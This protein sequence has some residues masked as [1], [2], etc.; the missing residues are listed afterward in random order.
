VGAGCRPDSQ[1][2]CCAGACD[3]VEATE[4][5]REKVE[6][7]GYPFG[8]RYMVLAAQSSSVVEMLWVGPVAQSSLLKLVPCKRPRVPLSV[9]IG[10]R[11][12]YALTT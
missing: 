1:G 5:V 6:A 4:G 10:T 12:C 9:C 3:G 8:Y 11:L 2:Q 7:S